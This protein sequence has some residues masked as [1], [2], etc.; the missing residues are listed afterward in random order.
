MIIHKLGQFSAA[1]V[2]LL[3]LVVC[4]DVDGA[5]RR[6][7]TVPKNPRAEYGHGLSPRESLEGWIS[8]FD[9]KTTY[10][11]QGANVKNGALSG[12]ATA[13]SKDATTTSKFGA[14]LVRISA[15]GSGEIR[16]GDHRLTAGPQVTEFEIKTKSPAAFQLGSQLQLRKLVIKP[17][18]M[19]QLFNRK[20]FTGWRILKHGN[21][22]RRQANWSIKDGAI[23]AVGGPGALESADKYGNAVIQIEVRTRAKLVNG[24]L[25]FRAIPGEFMNGY[26]AQI[27]NACYE[28]NE[29]K[30]AR[31]STG[32]IDDRMLARWL[33]SRDE[34]PFLMTVIAQNNHIATWVNGIQLT[35]WTDTRKPDTNP[36][37]GLRLEPG[38]I[39]L[40][41]HDPETNL[42]FRS[43]R[44]VS[45][46]SP[47][48]SRKP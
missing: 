7:W 13:T 29:R 36:R 27:F 44:V 11:W 1:G 40:Q 42:E 10:G 12:H 48:A 43:I 25:F 23:V 24:G 21:A 30:P 35:D 2:C 34:L 20:D 8:L 45:Y 6:D 19:Q 14:C 37:K 4:S 46:D 15:T 22:S 32:G 31:Y 9:G 28:N 38:T 16:F 3:V 18:G 41:A 47:A 17:A 33:P 5:D 39:Q 26:E